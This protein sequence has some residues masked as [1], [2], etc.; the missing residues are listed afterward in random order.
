MQTPS[1]SKQNSDEKPETIVHALINATKANPTKMAVYCGN[2]F[3]TYEEVNKRATGVAASLKDLG[4]CRGDR[5]AVIL[6]PSSAIFSL[7][8]GVMACGAQLTLINPRMPKA[9]LEILVE[10]SKPSLIIG[11]TNL[12]DL[13]KDFSKKMKTKLIS[14]KEDLIQINGGKLDSLELPS[15]NDIALILFTGGTTGSPK[16][17]PHTH[18]QVINAITAIEHRWTSRIG[19][20]VFLNIPPLFH[21]V[22]L[23]HGCFQ[24]VLS[25]STSVLL[26]SFD[27]SIVFKLFQELKVTI[28]VAGAPSSY[29]AM[30]NHPEFSKTDFNNLRFFCGGGAPL[31]SETLKEWE[32]ITGVPVLEGYGMTE[33]APT[34]NNPLN[35]TRKL[36]SVGKPV[37]GIELEIVDIETG[38]KLMPP[39][40]PGEIRVRGSHITVGYLDNIEETNNTFR[41]GWLYTGDIAYVDD[42]NYVFIIDRV[43]E[44]A[45]VS[46][47]NVFPREV[48]EALMSH[49]EISEAATIALPHKSKG[50]I[51]K[52]FIKLVSDSQITEDE[53]KDYCRERLI[54]YKIPS[55]IEFCT[56]LAKTPIGKIDKKLLKKN[57]IN[58]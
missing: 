35:G 37:L 11:D 17:V 13:L 16:G 36:L 2:Q 34:C 55:E 38:K 53:I 52:S 22:G 7:F 24:P 3:E 4:I 21:I 28:C 26:E 30:L 40:E 1:V 45:I 32:D 57:S 12:T 42:E 54:S 48:D 5:V 44:M 29:I 47:F 50:E 23:F 9:E 51:I 43:K 56:K 14:C 33:G 58:K 49:P 41:N 10:I 46:G 39:K 15:A 19:Q 31:A 25:N 18:K 27:P 20:E 8:F 6:P